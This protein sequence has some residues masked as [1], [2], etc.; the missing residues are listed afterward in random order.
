[1]RIMICLDVDFIVN[2]RSVS[3]SKVIIILNSQ[4]SIF[5]FDTASSFK[6]KFTLVKLCFKELT[7][8]VL[9]KLKLVTLPLKTG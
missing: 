6:M 9:L 2:S 8:F 3:S 4:L 7:V 1:M 5:N